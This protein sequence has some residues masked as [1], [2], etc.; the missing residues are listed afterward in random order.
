[1][2][3]KMLVADYF[4][5]VKNIIN[6]VYESQLENILKSADI[7][8]E[9]IISNGCV[10]VFG[11]GHAGIITEELF[12]RAGGLMLINPIFAPSLVTTVKPITITSK[13]EN[14]EGYGKIIIENSGIT[15]KDV[16]IVHSVSG[17]N[18]AAI[19][20]AQGALD[21]GSK[22]IVLTNLAFSKSVKSRHS[23][24]KKLYEIGA[25]V[26][27]DN[28]GVVGDA[29]IEINGLKQKVG[30]TSSISGCLIVNSIVVQVVE[31]LIK[32]EVTPPVFMSA[33]LDDGT[34]YNKELLSKYKDR[35]KYL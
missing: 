11:A 32:K 27:L 12:Y 8:T 14:L 10:Y 5:N 6:K 20:V 31:N 29:I 30:P 18:K 23:N 2:E 1:M 4:D 17:R 33:N 21:I 35:I 24:G 16:L 9:S 7:I 15:D 26:I 19:D 25:D 13:V 3:R 34:E 22:L 28:C